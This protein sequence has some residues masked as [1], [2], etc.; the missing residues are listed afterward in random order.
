MTDPDLDQ[1]LLDFGAVI[2]AI[3]AVPLAEDRQRDLM[4]AE[5]LP[6]L[7]SRDS[8]SFL[9][10]VGSGSVTADVP[11][12]GENETVFIDDL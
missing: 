2:D 9:D 12:S 11:V 3:R 1:R 8:I 7:P 5:R 6:M 4:P 10:G